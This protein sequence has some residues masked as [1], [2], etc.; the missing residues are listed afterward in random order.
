MT[1]QTTRSREPGASADPVHARPFGE[2]SGPAR[3]IAARRTVLVGR[4]RN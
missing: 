4:R 3:G 2:T 1:T